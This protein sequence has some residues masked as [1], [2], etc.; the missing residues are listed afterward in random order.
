MV[1]AFLARAE[2]PAVTRRQQRYRPSLQV[3]LQTFVRLALQ[4]APMGVFE[5]AT[6]FFQ[7]STQE[8]QL[9]KGMQPLRFVQAMKRAA[10]L[11][12]RPFFSVVPGLGL[13]HREYR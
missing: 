3:V 6:T 9:K 4:F 12:F 7:M 1:A 8:V 13:Q 10:V 5:V 11:A 2:A